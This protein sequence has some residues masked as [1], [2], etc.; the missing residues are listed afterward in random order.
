MGLV[1]E[2]WDP[3]ASRNSENYNGM[4]ILCMAELL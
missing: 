3:V 4:E 1:G 2:Q